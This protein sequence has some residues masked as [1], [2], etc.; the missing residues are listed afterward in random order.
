[1]A[2]VQEFVDNGIKDNKVFMI[3]KSYCPFCVKARKYLDQA[4]FKDCKIVEIENRKDC[5]AIQD[6]CAKI[7]GSRSVPKVWINGKFLG[8]GDETEAAF[9]NGSLQKML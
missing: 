6:Y 1:M 5:A 3:S 8:G 9:K 4:G 7:A 2:E